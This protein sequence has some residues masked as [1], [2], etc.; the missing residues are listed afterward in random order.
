[1]DNQKGPI[2]DERNLGDY[3]NVIMKRKKIFLT[4]F[5]AT[6]IA[7]A[8]MSL[9]AHKTYESVSLIRLGSIDEPLITKEEAKELLLSLDNLQAVIKELNL[10]ANPVSLKNQIVIE[11]VANSN[12]LRINV[13]FDSQD[14]AQR[15]NESLP[16]RLISYGQ[17][18]YEKRIM[19]ITERL[20]EL[21]QEIQS[22]DSNI[23]LTKSLIGE[24][25]QSRNNLN[26]A[27][28][29]LKINLL[30]NAIPAFEN[31]LSLLKSQRK[32][33]QMILAEAKEFGIQ[34]HAVSLPY[35]LGIS[36]KEKIVIAAIFALML[37]VFS[38]FLMEWWESQ[39]KNA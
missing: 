6:V 20:K 32:D 35:P 30:Q 16:V 10:N 39:K 26:Q 3:V 18:L 5:F 4:V 33:I 11:D 21:E 38:T 13:H 28:M 17:A 31:R 23:K 25:P 12:L 37:G 34:D 1:M 2:V 15:I 19:L 27:G 22:T 8:I 14:N 36:K 24:F 29:N 9:K 7:A